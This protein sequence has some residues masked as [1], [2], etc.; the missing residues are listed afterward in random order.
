MFYRI[1][2]CDV[3]SFL[4]V[5]L[6]KSMKK[7]VVI[8]VLGFCF[9]LVGMKVPFST[10]PVPDIAREFFEKLAVVKTAIDTS[11]VPGDTAVLKNLQE[12][13]LLFVHLAK[14][15]AQIKSVNRACYS[16]A[17]F[18]GVSALPARELV[19]GPVFAAV[20]YG[21]NVRLVALAGELKACRIALAGKGSQQKPPVE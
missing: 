2:A 15:F 6:K 1:S 5:G 4:L 8:C 16:F 20:R 3:D 18:I 14:T 7:V 13:E 19:I 11:M 9:S 17:K 12:A 10:R 21:I